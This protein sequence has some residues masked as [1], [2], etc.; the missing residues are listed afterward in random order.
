MSSAYNSEVKRKTDAK[1]SE[2]QKTEFL[3]D[4]AHRQDLCRSVLRGQGA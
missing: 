1:E 2:V 3:T 4:P